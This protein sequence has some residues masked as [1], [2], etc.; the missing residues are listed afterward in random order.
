MSKIAL[1]QIASPDDETQVDR[2]ARVETLLRSHAHSGVELFVLPELWSAGF[3]SFDRYGE[4]AEPFD[5]LTLTMC[6]RVARDLSAWVHVG[7]FIERAEN[8]QLHNTAVLLN[9]AGEVVQTYRKIQLYG[10]DTGE[11]SLLAPGDSLSA[12]E[13]PFG[14]VTMTTCYDLRSPGLWLEV[15]ARGADMAIVPAAWPAKRRDH[16]RLFTEARAVEHQIWV[17]AV[18]SCGVQVGTELGGISRVVDPWGHVLHES[19]PTEEGVAIID[20]D[21]ERVAEVRRDFPVMSDRLPLEAYRA[22][23]G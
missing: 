15:S 2:V 7:S 23:K 4:H 19:S 12:T 21:P 13:T 1:V 10:F 9:P 6:R 8:G 22:L 3:L 5:G 20:I 16:F 11:A 14:K 17:I 18:G